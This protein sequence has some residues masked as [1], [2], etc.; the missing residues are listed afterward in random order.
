MTTDLRDE[1]IKVGNAM[2]EQVLALTREN[3]ALRQQLTDAQAAPAP[4]A[5]ETVLV[6]AMIEAGCRALHECQ[7][8][9]DADAPM[10]HPAQK[11]WETPSMVRWQQWK[12][13]VCD[14]HKAML[15]A[16]PTPGET[17]DE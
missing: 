9:E 15:A 17:D 11:S 1:L 14:V 4:S 10:H 5:G 13:A 12:E 6:E 8:S 7:G 16:A 3:A 2:R